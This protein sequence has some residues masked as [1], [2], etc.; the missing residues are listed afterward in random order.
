MVSFV[1]AHRSRWP[2]APM[3]AAIELSERAYYAAKARPPP[4]RQVSDELQKVEIRRVWTANYQVYGARR[5]YEQR[6][7]EGYE[8]ARCAIV[9][10]IADMGIRGVQRGKKRFTT[11]VD[12]TAVRPADLVK[13][14]FVADR[15]NELWLAD[16]TYCSTCEGWLYVSFIMDVYSRMIVGW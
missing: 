7:R 9:R 11:V 4:A 14:R 8:L 3:C 13:R 15:P 12:E 6:G 1:D 2:V 16:I 5:I 10:L